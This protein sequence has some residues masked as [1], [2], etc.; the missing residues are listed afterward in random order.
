[1]NNDNSKGGFPKALA[2]LLVVFAV[3]LG[4]QTWYVFNIR[5]ELKSLR[6][7]QGMADGGHAAVSTGPWMMNHHN[8]M[9]NAFDPDTWNPFEEMHHMQEQMDRMFGEAFGRF[10]SSPHFRGLSGLRDFTPRVDVEEKSDHYVVVVDLPGTKESDVSITLEDQTLTISGTREF[11]NEK[12]DESGNSQVLRRE[13]RLGKFQRSVTFAN[14][15]DPSG[16][17]SDFDGGVLTI[18][19]PKKEKS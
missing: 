6:E 4:I 18:N 13:R 15:V 9:G 2:V 17:K 10:D 14:P 5:H 1:M 12:K 3:L 8:G 16:M 19:I 7:D 11:T